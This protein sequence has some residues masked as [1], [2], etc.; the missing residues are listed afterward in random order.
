MGEIICRL[1]NRIH[2]AESSSLDH[3]KSNHQKRVATF[4]L[5]N[6]KALSPVEFMVPA[7]ATSADVD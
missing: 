6:G 2:D 3:A 7:H 4:K 1:H 5:T